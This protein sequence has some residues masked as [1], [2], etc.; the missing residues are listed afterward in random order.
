MIIF[1]QLNIF[2]VFLA[3]IV[4]CSSHDIM[5]T[6]LITAETLKMTSGHYAFLYLSFD[7]SPFEFRRSRKRDEG[8]GGKKEEMMGCVLQLGHFPNL[9]NHQSSKLGAVTEYGLPESL[10]SLS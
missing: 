1:S 4:V 7:F 3:A 8:G 10:V 5:Q 9:D 2:N 6:I